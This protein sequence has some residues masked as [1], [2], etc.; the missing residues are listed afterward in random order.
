MFKRNIVILIEDHITI[1][2]DMGRTCWIKNNFYYSKGLHQLP[3]YFG[4]V[5]KY[6]L[7]IFVYFTHSTVPFLIVF[8]TILRLAF[9]VYG[10]L[11]KIKLSS[12]GS[13]L[14]D[15]HLFDLV[16]SLKCWLP[17]IY[18]DEFVPKRNVFA[19]LNERRS[20]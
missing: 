4:K 8:W 19:H 11:L 14:C 3:T 2:I 1:T 16:R 7:V 9:R 12:L 17:R 10:A 5:E 15:Q 18:I 20:A 13:Y 6:F